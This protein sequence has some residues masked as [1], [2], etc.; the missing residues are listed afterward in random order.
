[1]IMNKKLN[2]GVYG[3]MADD[4]QELLNEYKQT[5]KITI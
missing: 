2:D 3:L 1:M 4:T 5:G